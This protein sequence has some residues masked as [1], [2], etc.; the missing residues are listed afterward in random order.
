MLIRA[1][2]SGRHRFVEWPPEKKAI[3]IGDF[4]ADSSLIEGAVGWRPVTSLRDG[5]A[6]TIEFYRAHMHHYVPTTASEVAAL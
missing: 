4:Y 5:L 1:A 3:D 6:R 2:G